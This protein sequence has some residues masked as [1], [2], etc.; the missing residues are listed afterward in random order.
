MSQRVQELNC[1]MPIE[2]LS[3]VLT[4]G[5]LSHENAS[6]IKHASVAMQ[7]IQDKRDI[8]TVPNGLKLHQYANLYFFARN[9]MLYKRLGEASKLTVIRINKNILTTQNAVMSDQNAAS[10]YASFYAYPIGLLKINFDFV[11]ADWWDDEDPG[12]AYRKKSTKCAEVLIPGVVPPAYITGFYAL[13]TQTQ[14][15]I[16]K[17]LSDSGSNLPVTVN[18]HMF[19][20]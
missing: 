4:H 20:R 12:T 3:S 16:V 8:K 6:K 5:I 7:E 17:T 2:N 19:F 1:I 13:D 9:P 11:F 14:S 18:S 15:T 10:D